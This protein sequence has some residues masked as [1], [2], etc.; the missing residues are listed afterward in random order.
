MSCNAELQL[1]RRLFPPPF[2]IFRNP[3]LFKSVCVGGEG[4]RLEGAM[5]RKES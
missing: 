3:R 2:M 1:S 5:E 4:E